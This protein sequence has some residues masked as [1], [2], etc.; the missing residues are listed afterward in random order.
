LLVFCRYPESDPALRSPACG[1][2]KSNARAGSTFQARAG[3]GLRAARISAIREESTVLLI[4][5]MEKTAVDEIAAW[6]NKPS[7]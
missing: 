3:F 6:M 1:R 7:S 2:F 5:G 4:P